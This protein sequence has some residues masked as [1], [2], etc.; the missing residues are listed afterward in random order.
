MISMSVLADTLKTRGLQTETATGPK[1]RI[2]QSVA[3]GAGSTV[4][5]SETPVELPYTA[6]GSPAAPREMGDWMKSPT[7]LRVDGFIAV[8]VLRAA[9]VIAVVAG[10]LRAVDSLRAADGIIYY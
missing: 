9:V 7:N 8:D 2:P 5:P 1:P 10:G 3:E 6:L 4:L